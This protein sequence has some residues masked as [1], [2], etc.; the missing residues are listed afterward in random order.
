LGSAE[1]VAARGGNRSNSREERV[2][3]KRM[4]G[5][6]K[7]LQERARQLR[8]AMTPAEAVLWKELRGWPAARFRRQHPLGRFVLDFY[9][10]SVRLCVEVDGAVHEDS[11][12]RERDVARSEALTA[13]GIRVI[14]FRNEEVLSNPDAVLRRIQEAITAA[15]TAAPPNPRPLAGEGGEPKRAG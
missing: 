1:R 7:E 2:K 15:S 12:Q 3:E 5:T 13:I 10:P 8:R 9:A 11:D 4:R 6:S 14:R